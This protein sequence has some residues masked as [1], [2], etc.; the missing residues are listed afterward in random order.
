[1]KAYR[2]RVI[3]SL[4]LLGDIRNQL[5]TQIVNIA[6]DGELKEIMDVFEEGDCY[7]FE[8]DQFENSKDINIVKLM[9][10]CKDIELAFDSIQNVNAVGDEEIFL[11]AS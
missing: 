7:E 1:M 10:L 8:M 9:Q 4:Q 6:S 5:F 11:T 3:E 2:N